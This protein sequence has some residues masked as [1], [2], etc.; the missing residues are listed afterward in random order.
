MYQ[1][2]FYSRRVIEKRN[3]RLRRLEKKFNYSD[4]SSGYDNYHDD[5]HDNTET[6]NGNLDESVMTIFLVLNNNFYISKINVALNGDVFGDENI[7]ADDRPF[8]STLVSQIWYVFFVNS[9]LL[10]FSRFM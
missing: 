7:I 5:E 3:R 1:K 9:L 8:K 6:S 10:F 2:S 4:I